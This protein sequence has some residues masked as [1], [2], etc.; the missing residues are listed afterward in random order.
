MARCTTNHSDS[1]AAVKITTPLARILPIISSS[2]VTGITSRCSIVPRSRSRITAA[3]VSNISNR[4][5]IVPICEVGMNHELSPL[6]L[7]SA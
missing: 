7:N 1:M 5:A 3:P 4:N 2:A 6:G